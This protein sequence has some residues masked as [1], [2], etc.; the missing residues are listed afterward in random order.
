MVKVGFQDSSVMAIWELGQTKSLHN[1]RAEV[2]KR[3]RCSMARSIGGWE[4]FE[5]E[6]GL[7]PFLWSCPATGRFTVGSIRAWAGPDLGPSLFQKL[8]L[9]AEG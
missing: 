3:V 6:S 8:H 1:V 2:R 7:S 5:K 4:E 9:Q